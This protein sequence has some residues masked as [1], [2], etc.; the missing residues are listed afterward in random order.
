MKLFYSEIHGLA[1]V[2][3]NGQSELA[4]IMSGIEKNFYGKITPENIVASIVPDDR[5]KKGFIK[6]YTIGENLIL[7]RA[8]NSIHTRRSLE[9][10]SES[11]IN[12]FDVR[13]PGPDVCVG[14]LSGGNQQKAVIAREIATGKDVMIFS[15]PTRGVDINAALSICSRIVD[16]RNRGKAILLISSDLEELLN[17]SDRLSI[18]Y[19]GNIVKTFG[20]A[21]L[22][23][24]TDDPTQGTKERDKLMIEIGR[25]MTGVQD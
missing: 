23:K 13:A 12:E 24:L 22:D 9:R 15:H 11:V 1:G 7:K 8:G 2:E 5:L 25:Y 17:L 19:K 6:E 3:G 20:K 4:D 10:D 16:E 14:A 21:E 18:I